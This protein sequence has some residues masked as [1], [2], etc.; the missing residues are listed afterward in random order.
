MF[1]VKKLSLYYCCPTIRIFGYSNGVWSQFIRIIGFQLYVQTNLFILNNYTTGILVTIW[2]TWVNKIIITYIKW[3]NIVGTLNNYLTSTHI[4]LCSR[5]TL[6]QII[7]Y[8]TSGLSLVNMWQAITLNLVLS[9]GAKNHPK[10][11]Y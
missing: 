10:K 5:T 7:D 9:R 8:N 6:L 2:L 1:F 3:L 4:N 11:A